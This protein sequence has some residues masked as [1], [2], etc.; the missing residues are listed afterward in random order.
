MA[1]KLE[2]KGFCQKEIKGDENY[3][4]KNNMQKTLS[5]RKRVTTTYRC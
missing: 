2:K 3:R 1:P 5:N 4:K